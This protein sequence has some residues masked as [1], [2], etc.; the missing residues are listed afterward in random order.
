MTIATT[1]NPAIMELPL[2]WPLAAWP[3]FP[4]LALFYTKEGD[5]AITPLRDADDCVPRLQRPPRRARVFDTV[6]THERQR[7]PA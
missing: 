2:P 4:R 1:L 6:K 7:K 3:P 5:L